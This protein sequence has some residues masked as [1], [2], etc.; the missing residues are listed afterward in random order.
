MDLDP[1]P[2]LSEEV[3]DEVS[4]ANRE[5]SEEIDHENIVAG[6]STSTLCLD[7]SVEDKEEEED[8][9]DGDP[10]C[11]LGPDKTACWKH[12]G[13]ESFKIARQDFLELEK[14]ELDLVV[15][16]QLRSSRSLKGSSHIY[17]NYQFGGKTICRKAFMFINNIGIHKL[18]NLMAHYDMHGVRSRIHKNTK[19]RPH[20]QTE[21]QSII[22]KFADNH[23]LPLPG[24]LPSHK[25]YRVMLLPSDICRLICARV[26]SIVSTKGA[27]KLTMYLL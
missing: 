16:A 23:A 5:F 17:V 8:F 10:C 4:T 14:A 19:K 6:P 21:V 7:E 11:S 9:F 1:I 13:R 25:D 26:L 3:N 22:L 24:R 27:V 2:G 15:L 20:N 12:Y 18:K